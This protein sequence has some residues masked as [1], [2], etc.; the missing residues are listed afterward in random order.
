MALK[1]LCHSD[2]ID[3][4]SMGKANATP[5]VSLNQLSH[6]VSGK[7]TAAT[8]ALSRTSDTVHDDKLF[9]Q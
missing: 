1:Q 4:D 2:Q 5:L 6:L 9:G 3:N 7:A 8:P